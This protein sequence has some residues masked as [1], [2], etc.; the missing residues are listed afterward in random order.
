M[1]RLL[2]LLMTFSESRLSLLILRFRSGESG[3]GQGE[4]RARLIRSLRARDFERAGLIHLVDSYELFG[5]QRFNAVKIIVRVGLFDIG[6]FDRGLGIR[7]IRPRLIYCR[8]GTLQTGFRPQRPGLF[9]IYS[10]H[11]SRDE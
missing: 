2:H 5:Q 11:P 7:Y 10:P 9:Y 8:G 3:L 1:R 6:A 4:L